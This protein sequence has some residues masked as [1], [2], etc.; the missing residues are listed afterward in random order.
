MYRESFHYKFNETNLRK[1]V[2]PWYFES[3]HG[4]LQTTLPTVL[5]PDRA[6]IEV[7]SQDNPS[8]QM[9][10]IYLHTFSSNRA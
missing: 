4:I 2:M 6:R 3:R 7:C 10:W 9:K 1:L 8:G 5:R